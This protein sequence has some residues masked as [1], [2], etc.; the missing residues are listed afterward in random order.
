MAKVDPHGARSS[1]MARFGHERFDF[2]S[3][4]YQLAAATSRKRKPNLGF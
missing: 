2:G 3:C 4:F 1:R